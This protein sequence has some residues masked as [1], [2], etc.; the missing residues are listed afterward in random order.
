M[1]CYHAKSRKLK[2]NKKGGDSLKKITNKNFNLER[3]KYETA[4]EFGLLHR[5]EQQKES[6]KKKLKMGKD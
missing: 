5:E 3:F 6:N 4:Q 2:E 1:V